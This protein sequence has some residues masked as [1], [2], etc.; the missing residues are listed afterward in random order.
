MKNYFTLSLMIFLH[1]D[2]VDKSI[3]IYMH[4]YTHTHTLSLPFSITNINNQS[5]SEALFLLVYIDI[6]TP[7]INTILL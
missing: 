7:I 3:C 1:L 5:I 4:V 6:P 2:Q